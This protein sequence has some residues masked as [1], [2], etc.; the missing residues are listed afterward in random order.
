MA[1][2]TAP[3][4]QP[5]ALTE[6]AALMQAAVD[7]I[8]VIEAGETIVAFSRSAERMFGYSADE[9]IGQQVNILM[10]QPYRSA[11]S[12]Y[13]E[14]Y[15][16]S[17]EPHIIGVGR[18]VRAVRKD[19]LIFPVWLSV[20]EARSRS[21]HRYIGIIRDLTKQHA[22]ETDRRS[23]EMRLEH[24]SR[25]SLLGEMAAGIAHEINQPLTAIANYSQAVRNV[26]SREAVDPRLL[27]TACEGIAEQVQRAGDV[28]KNLRKFVRNREIESQRLN[29]KTLVDGVMVLI[30]A[31]AAHESVS[32]E[33][34]LSDSLPEVSGNAVQL[35]QVL[36]NLTHNAVD[37][38]R[39][40]KRR[41][42]ILTIET[43]ET[44]DGRVEIQVSDRGSGVSSNLEAAIFHPFFTT[45]QHG[46]GVGLAI[47]RSIVEAHGGQLSYERRD[48]GGSTFVVT[49]PILT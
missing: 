4:K 32:V 34:A 11:H 37:A 16:E 46:L 23:L 43:R 18:E 9:V 10:P 13:I 3:T 39:D 8:V 26:L 7:A 20:G 22:A 30:H 40:N 21:G 36:L 38:M 1:K 48:G 24:V 29:L 42:K 49:L 31:D 2:R 5:A 35:Q 12:S 19:G 14:R 45:K 28:I 41:P 15:E 25:L 27:A 44:S 33:T 17:G 47:S 6:M